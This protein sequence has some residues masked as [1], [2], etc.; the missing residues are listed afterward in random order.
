MFN[1][2][3]IVCLT[4]YTKMM[5]VRCY[6]YLNINKWVLSYWCYNGIQ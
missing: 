6:D 5:S 2:L 1:R 4:F 3:P